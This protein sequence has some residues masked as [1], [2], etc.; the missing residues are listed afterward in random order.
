MTVNIEG[1][2]VVHQDARIAV[3]VS[4]F[5]DLLTSHMLQAAVQTYQR[6]GGDPEKLTIVHVPG[7]LELA[8]TALKLGESSAYEAIL[9]LGCVIRGETDHY[10]H[11]CEQAAKGIREAGLKTGVP[12]LYGIV[13]ADTVEQA[14][15]RCGV[16]MGN[17]GGR[18]MMAT[19]EM[20]NLM[21]KIERAPGKDVQ[22]T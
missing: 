3:V 7:G 8:V 6:L 15:N 11:V 5:N 22:T 10:D 4:R 18:D 14:V 13:T 17:Q 9:C 21:K 16:K 1:D 19:I 2:L 20:A 12:T